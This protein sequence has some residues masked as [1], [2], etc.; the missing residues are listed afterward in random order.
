MK[1]TD[2]ILNLKEKQIYIS[3]ASWIIE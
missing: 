1:N 2:I 3:N